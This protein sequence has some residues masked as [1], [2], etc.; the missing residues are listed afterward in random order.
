MAKKDDGLHS[1]DSGDESSSRSIRVCLPYALWRVAF[2]V[3]V[4]EPYKWRELVAN[5]GVTLTGISSW[6]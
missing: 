6:R 1:D 4:S 2:P 5:D 3:R